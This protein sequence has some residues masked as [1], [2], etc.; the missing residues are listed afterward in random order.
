M[1]N[2]GTYKYLQTKGT[3]VEEA[4]WPIAVANHSGRWCWIPSIASHSSRR[5][6]P[7]PNLMIPCSARSSPSYSMAL[8]TSPASLSPSSSIH[9]GTRGFRSLA[10]RDKASSQSLRSSRSVAQE[11]EWSA[12]MHWPQQRQVNFNECATTPGDTF[13]YGSQPY[14]A[15]LRS[16]HSQG[17]SRAVLSAVSQVL[18]WQ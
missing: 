16:V 8:M 1:Q 5:I 11:P 3:P 18:R 6:R 14:T 17:T 13:A 10:C 7:S 9:P 15:R 12:L 2:V 4:A